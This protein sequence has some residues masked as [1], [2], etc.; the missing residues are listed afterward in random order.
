MSTGFSFPYNRILVTGATGFVGGRLV[1]RLVTQ[2]QI[3]PRVLVRR[4]HRAVRVAR[5][6]VDVIQGDVLEPSDVEKAVTG[7]DVV[8]HCAYGNSGNEETQRRITVDGTRNVMHKSLQAGVKRVVY[9]STPLVYGIPPDGELDETAPRTYTNDLYSDSKLDAEKI[10]VEF[11]QKYG[12]PVV[13]LQP[14]VIYGPFAPPW[15]LNVLKL[16]KRGR[17][18]LINDGEGFCNAVYI[19][20][21]I[22]ATLQAAVQ[23]NVGGECFL[24]SS[25]EV[26]TWREFYGAFEKMLGIS[27][28]VSMTPAEANAYYETTLQKPKSVLSETLSILRHEALIRNRVLQT[29]ELKFLSK[30]TK[31]AL[32]QSFMDLFKKRFQGNGKNPE[33]GTPPNRVKPINPLPPLMIQFYQAKSKVRID[34]ARQ[35][36]KY[37]PAF[38]FLTGMRLT[39]EWARWANLLEQ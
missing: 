38:D 27:S 23:A 15:T 20:D 2:F 6:S 4:F 30:A 12:L 35:L 3:K 14:T 16:L 7:C 37:E 17:Q 13:V 21:V 9:I 22:S 29:R 24:I 32:P 34:K 11:A 39:E 28:S 10:A 33:S 31:L 26:I 18:I 36:L 25:G 19:D 1:E 8:F 5:F